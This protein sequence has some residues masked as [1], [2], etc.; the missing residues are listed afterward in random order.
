MNSETSF[1]IKDGSISEILERY[2]TKM[3]LSKDD[4]LAL[5]ESNDILYLNFQPL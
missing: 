3:T 1:S 4:A 2:Q 5:L